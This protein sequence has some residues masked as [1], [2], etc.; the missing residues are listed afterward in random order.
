VD[1]S[2]ALTH[3]CNL[4][5]TYCYAGEK[6]RD[7]MSA[8]IADRAIDFAFSFGA[9]K[10]QLGF[11]GGE[12]LIE[13]DLLQAAALRAEGKAQAADT[14][15]QKTVTTNGTLLTSDRVAWLREHDFYP[16]LS[17]DGNRAMHDVTR[18]HCAGRSSFEATRRGLKL[19]QE[20]FPEVEVIVVPDPANV[21]HLAESVRFLVEEQQ[22]LRISI[23]P[24]F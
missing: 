7:S 6:R 16:A 21:K 4:A 15:L 13:W 23:N 10:L 14:E 11:F 19:L 17:L 8:E 24:N 9:P 5:C 20:W 12:P 2:L 22:V 1:V 3:D 18:P